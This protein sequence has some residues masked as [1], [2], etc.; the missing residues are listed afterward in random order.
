MEPVADMLTVADTDDPKV[1]K[2]WFKA[3]D[4][5]EKRQLGAEFNARLLSIRAQT[6]K[7]DTPNHPV[8]PTL[9]PSAHAFWLNYPYIYHTVPVSGPVYPDGLIRGQWPTRGLPDWAK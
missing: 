1:L 2:A 3:L 5:D 8:E 4:P 6:P 9:D 7:P